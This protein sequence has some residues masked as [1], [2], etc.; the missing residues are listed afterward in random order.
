M[1][2]KT[3]LDDLRTGRASVA[4]VGLGYVG[5]PLAVALSRHFPVIGFDISQKRVD[6]LAKGADRTGEVL[7]HDLKSAKVAYTCDP[8]RLKDAAVIIVA[9]P[10]PG[11]T[12]S[13]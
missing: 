5:L 8:A 9:V 10:T 7:T 4:V 13:R 2:L 6:E 3:S 11:S 12:L 1:G